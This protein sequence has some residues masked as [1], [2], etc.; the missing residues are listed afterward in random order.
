MFIYLPATFISPRTCYKLDFPMGKLIKLPPQS[1]ETNLVEMPT[2]PT[3]GRQVGVHG[4]LR[5]YK[6]LGIAPEGAVEQVKCGLPAEVGN[7]RVG[8]NPNIP[9]NQLLLGI[10]PAIISPQTR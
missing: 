10:C 7:I 4:I 6:G 3:P 5:N 1:Q 8:M 9:S 2:W